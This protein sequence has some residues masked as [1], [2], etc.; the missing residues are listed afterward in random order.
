MRYPTE[1][2]SS[3]TSSLLSLT[4][5]LA[6]H[7]QLLLT[8]VGARSHLFAETIH[9]LLGLSQD[10]IDEGLLSRTGSAPQFARDDRHGIFISGQGYEVHVIG[11]ACADLDR[12]SVDRTIG[13]DGSGRRD[14]LNVH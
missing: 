11:D 2:R 5:L 12:G 13:S 8:L 3:G 10:G 4:V 6:L 1:P 9:E 7:L 14:G